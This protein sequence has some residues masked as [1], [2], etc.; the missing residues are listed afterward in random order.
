MSL[1]ELQILIE[2]YKHKAKESYLSK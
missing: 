1:T 2:K